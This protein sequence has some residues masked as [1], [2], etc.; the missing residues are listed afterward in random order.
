MEDM[1]E[2]IAK[3]VQNEVKRGN[4]NMQGIIKRVME[5][6]MKKFQNKIE[7]GEI[8]V[9]DLKKSAEKLMSQIGNPAALI[10]LGKQG[11]LTQNQKRKARRERLRKRLENKQINK[12]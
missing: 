10:G 11:Q 6:V 3:E 2:I 4:T 1:V 8:D 12:S 5:K 9:E 7:N